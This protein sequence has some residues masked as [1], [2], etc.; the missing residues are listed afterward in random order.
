MEPGENEADVIFDLLGRR[1]SFRIS[2]TREIQVGLSIKESIELFSCDGELQINFLSNT[3]Q[4]I[5]NL[6][7][8]GLDF[9]AD[10]V[11]KRAYSQLHKLVL[12]H[13]QFNPANL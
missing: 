7:I 1:H 5:K 9:A 2:K 6:K 10:S 4:E 13:M 12:T 11:H 8:Y 3:A